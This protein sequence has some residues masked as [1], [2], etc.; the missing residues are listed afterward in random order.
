MKIGIMGTRGIPNYYGGFEYFATK[1]SVG[2]AERGHQV[3][4]YN[5]HNHPN[6]QK[7]WNGVRIRHCYNPESW[8]GAAGQFIYDLNCFRDA[9]HHDLDILLQLGYT[10]SSAWHRFWPKRPLHIINMDG[11]EWKRNKYN[12]VTRKFLRY[13]ENLAVKKANVLVADS[14][15]IRDY[16][17]KACNS[18][19]YYIPY[20][21]DHIYDA[22]AAL[23][24]PLNLQ[25][26]EFY[27]MMAR[28]EPENNIETVIRGYLQSSMP[29]PLVIAGS[30]ATRHGKYLE[31]KYR[32]PQIIFLGS[33]YQPALVDSLLF[34]NHYY[35]HGHSVGGTNPSLLQ[36]MAAGC[37]IAA[38][39]NDFNFAVLGE[40]ANY[41]TNPADI[42]SV[43]DQ[44]PAPAILSGRRTRNH[45]KLEQEYSWEDIIDQYENLFAAQLRSRAHG[46][47]TE[48]VL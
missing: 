45:R 25:A 11:L 13:A 24:E 26:G 4:V 47:L 48:L 14:P 21:A 17:K 46:L 29:Y 39:D 16:L 9:H 43:I 30:T 34:Y 31:K 2:L 22:D 5:P 6:Q 44:P 1:L 40:H 36:A 19:S 8:L 10:S 27:F 33:V 23:L 12:K 18:A 37:S 28:L 32:H 20:G 38:H 41:F 42:A 7:S 35:F 3:F 15:V